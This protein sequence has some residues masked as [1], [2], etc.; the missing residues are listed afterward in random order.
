MTTQSITSTPARKLVGSRQAGQI[1]RFAEIA[2]Y[3][4]AQ[5]AL[6]D[7]RMCTE[8]FS[9]TAQMKIIACG[10]DFQ[11]LLKPQFE[12]II[13]AAINQLSGRRHAAADDIER[14]Y[15]E[16]LGRKIDLTG[17]TFPEKEGFPV[18]MAV[19][20][21]L[22]EDMVLG[23]ITEYFKV[24]K[25]TWLS[26]VAENIDR[27]TE[28]KRPEGIYAFAHV[29]GD[30]P[31]AKHLGKSY[32]DAMG[33]KMIF[34]NPLEYPLMTGFHMWKHRKWMDSKGF[35]RTSSLWCDGGLVGG[36]WDPDRREVYVGDGGRG[37]RVPGGG[38]RELFLG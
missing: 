31:D 25:W 15:A 19:V 26:P 12:K 21:G 6:S 36:C 1:A 38:P 14:F 13:T 2:A 34:A 16:V 18:Y 4:A 10:N 7:N 29:G 5:N 30:E 9:D 24:G 22:D 8:L 23:S 32:D 17:V 37:H 27:K 3:D 20:P 33:A 35:T 28:Q 11:A